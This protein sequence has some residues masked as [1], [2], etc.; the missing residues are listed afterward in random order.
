M[1]NLAFIFFNNPDIMG[2]NYWNPLFTFLSIKVIA[3][4]IVIF[5]LLLF[6]FLKRRN[7][8]KE[9][10]SRTKFSFQKVNTGMSVFYEMIQNNPI[11]VLE[12]KFRSNLLASEFFDDK[13]NLNGSLFKK[14]GEIT[15]EKDGRVVGVLSFKDTLGVQAGCI[16]NEIPYVIIGILFNEKDK[17]RIEGEIL[18]RFDSLGPT[19]TFFANIGH[20]SD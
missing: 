2:D 9:S 7:K 18:F 12:G 5:L 13:D 1:K 19:G 15:L 20:Y 8:K 11:R 17:E 3:L 4:V 14:E 6:S 10:Q 16:T